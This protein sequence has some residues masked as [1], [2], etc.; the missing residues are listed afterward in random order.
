MNSLAPFLSAFE[1]HRDFSDA[2]FK[3]PGV[4]GV[5]IGYCEQNG[6]LTDEPCIKVAIRNSRGFNYPAIPT[7]HALKFGSERFQLP[8][9]FLELG[10]I[11]LQASPSGGLHTYT[12]SGQYFETATACCLV[13]AGG[14]GRFL[15]GCAH[16]F[17]LMRTHGRPHE[18]GFRAYST[19]ADDSGFH[20]H[21]GMLASVA[22][23]NVVD[24][25]LVYA[26]N[27]VSPRYTGNRQFTGV[28]PRSRLLSSYN[29][30]TR[31]G[32]KGLHLD[33]VG[34]VNHPIGGA[35][36]NYDSVL[37]SRP[38]SRESSAGDSGAPLVSGQGEL[39]G[40]HF[41]KATSGH[42]LAFRIQDVFQAFSP[43]LQLIV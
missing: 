37:I 22:D 41:G 4:T 6:K 14:T 40:M 15:L 21:V 11:E 38:H 1:L 32:I 39:L 34:R 31:S 8:V 9:E 28:V 26:N 3:I 20:N 13:S 30:F 43:N 27:N 17:A 2:V 23:G 33:M 10:E 19:A 25:A 18:S 29:M 16:A 24:A 36:A 35:I 42:A 5:G 7:S 12:Q